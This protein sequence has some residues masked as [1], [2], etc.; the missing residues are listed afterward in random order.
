LPVD[1]YFLTFDVEKMKLVVDTNT[2]IGSIPI[3]AFVSIFLFM[4]AIAHFHVVLPGINKF[5]NSRLEMGTN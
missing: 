1:F 5:Y 4:S 2:T 3:G